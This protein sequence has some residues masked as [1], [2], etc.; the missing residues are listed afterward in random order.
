MLVSLPIILFFLPLLS[1]TDN[2]EPQRERKL[3]LLDKLADFLFPLYPL[4]FFNP[5]NIHYNTS[6][7]DMKRRIKMIAQWLQ[8]HF[9]V[10]SCF[11]CLFGLFLC[12]LSRRL[13]A[14]G[15]SWSGNCLKMLFI[16][17]STDFTGD[18]T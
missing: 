7:A 8:N 14:I 2:T 9:R 4:F 15:G 1:K 16:F 13:L 10:S 12:S 18:F 11:F 6:L 5:L 17:Q 3:P